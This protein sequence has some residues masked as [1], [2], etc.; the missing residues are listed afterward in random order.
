VTREVVVRGRERFNIFCSPCH[1]Y[2]GTGNGMIVQR[3]LK[4]PPSFHADRLRG[5][6]VGHFFDV[7]TNGYGA[8]FSYGSRIPV[9]DRWAIIAYIRALQLSQNAPA[10]AIPQDVRNTL[11]QGQ[12]VTLPAFK[13]RQGN[14]TLGGLPTLGRMLPVNKEELEGEP[15]RGLND[16]TK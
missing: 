11:T 14:L 6:P 15:P 8:M 2:A 9:S 7:I 1:D 4:A 10:D 13:P 5:A 16:A 3:G 12:Q